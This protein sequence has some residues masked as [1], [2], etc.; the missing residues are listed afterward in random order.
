MLCLWTGFKLRGRGGLGLF[1]REIQTPTCYDTSNNRNNYNSGRNAYSRLRLKDVHSILKQNCCINKSVG[2]SDGGSVGVNQID[3]YGTKT[4]VFSYPKSFQ[5]Y[6]S[7]QREI[8]SSHEGSISCIYIYYAI[9]LTSAIFSTGTSTSLTSSPS[10]GIGAGFSIAV[11]AANLSGVHLC[12][13]AGW[14]AGNNG[15]PGLTWMF[16][17]AVP[18]G[19]A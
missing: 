6:E 14:E 5:S 4:R 3:G 17:L 15:S 13:A 1:K 9:T 8:N 16:S 2:G 12:F 11:A 19:T 18:P 10:A 7:Q